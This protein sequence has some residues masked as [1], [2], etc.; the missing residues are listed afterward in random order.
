VS[1]QAGER[2]LIGVMIFPEIAIRIKPL[3]WRNDVACPKSALSRRG[4][5]V[6]PVKEEPCLQFAYPYPCPVLA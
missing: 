1:R 3:F 6:R 4:R 2:S 5:R